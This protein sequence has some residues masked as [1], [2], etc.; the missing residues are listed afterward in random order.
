MPSSR[1]TARTSARTNAGTKGVPRADRELQIVRTAAE[2]FGNDGF[3][4]ASVATVAE[5]AGISKPLVYQYFGSKEGLFSAVIH[6][7]GAQ[8]A[9]EMER[10]ARGDSVGLERGLR[11]LD[12]LFRFLE[13][14]PWL[15]RIFFDSTAPTDG[16]VAL[17]L[18]QYME[19]ITELAL[20]GVGELMSLL[21]DDDPLDVSAMTSVWMNISDALV[22]WWIDHPEVTPSDM[23]ARCYRLFA[24]VAGAGLPPLDLAD[25]HL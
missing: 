10:I 22:T 5:R 20:E 9:D 2:V 21:G 24:A 7:G 14:Q 25:L 4:R 1:P 17:A 16:E 8:L 19:R 23:T 6:Y 11:T 3:A 13:P 18:A 12:G 15:W